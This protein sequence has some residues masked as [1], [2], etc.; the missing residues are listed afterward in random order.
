MKLHADLG[1]CF[2]V[3]FV[4]LDVVMSF[5]HVFV[6]VIQA[7]YRAVGESRAREGSPGMVSFTC[8][9]YFLV[10]RPLVYNHVKP[11]IS[12]S[13]SLVYAV[14]TCIILVFAASQVGLSGGQSS[15]SHTEP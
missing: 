2:V 1:Q 9:T 6:F 11:H 14:C 7:L 13:G 5:Y 10:L 12:L 15:Y 8:Q 3:I 4:D